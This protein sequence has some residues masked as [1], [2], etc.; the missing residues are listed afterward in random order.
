MHLRRDSLAAVESVKAASDVYA[1]L[2]GT[3][4]ETNSALGDNPALVNSS[5]EGEGWFVKLEVEDEGEIKSLMD[6]T[7]YAAHCEDAKH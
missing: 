4:V 3:V 6:G 5:A 7:Q 1:P 2:S